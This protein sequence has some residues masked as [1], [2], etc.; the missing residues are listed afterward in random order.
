MSIPPAVNIFEAIQYDGK[1]G[2]TI[3]ELLDDPPSQMGFLGNGSL[4]V[5]T[6]DMRYTIVPKG[7]YVVRWNSGAV[8]VSDGSILKGRMKAP[9]DV[10]TEMQKVEDA[11]VRKA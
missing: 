2:D 1:N 5:L 7:Y 4:L 11:Q 9:V 8:E 3:A 6:N 10:I